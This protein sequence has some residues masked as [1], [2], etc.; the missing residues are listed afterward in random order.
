MQL[1]SENINQL[2]EAQKLGDPRKE[3]VALKSLHKKNKRSKNLPFFF[4]EK[5]SWGISDCWNWCGCTDSTGYGRTSNRFTNQNFAHRWSYELFNGEIPDGLK[6]LHKCDNPSCVNPEHLFLGTQQENVQDMVQ[7]GRHVYG[8]GKGEKSPNH[9]LTKE[10]V[11]EMRK[12][13]ESKK[14]T[15]KQLAKMFNISVMTMYRAVTKR[16]WGNV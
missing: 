1:N 10:E 4:F 11:L 16:S 2:I 3:A 9:K 14:Y 7:K 13:Y 8:L 15:Y 5:I 6:V 12:A